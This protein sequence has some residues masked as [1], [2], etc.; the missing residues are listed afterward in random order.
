MHRKGLRHSF[1][2]AA[3]CVLESSDGRN[4]TLRA[5]GT[6]PKPNRDQTNNG[7][8]WGK[9]FESNGVLPGSLCELG[10]AGALP[11]ALAREGRIGGVSSLKHLDVSVEVADS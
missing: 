3:H 6:A 1:L 10:H 7:E 5:R 4:A 8:V 9:R 2:I 11:H